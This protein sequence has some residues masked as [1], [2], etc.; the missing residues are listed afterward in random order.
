VI[1]KLKWPVNNQFLHKAVKRKR[2]YSK[3]HYPDVVSNEQGSSHLT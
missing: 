1:G 3:R 2:D